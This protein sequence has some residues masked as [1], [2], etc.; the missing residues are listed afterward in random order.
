L[1]FLVF[2][3]VAVGYATLNIIKEKRLVSKMHF[4]K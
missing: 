4:Y 3:Q 2:A 1:K